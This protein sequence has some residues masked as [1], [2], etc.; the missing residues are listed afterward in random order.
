M[1]M[2]DIVSRNGEQDVSAGWCDIYESKANVC[3]RLPYWLISM[4][5]ME[6]YGCRNEMDPC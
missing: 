5:G 3:M 1:I 2:R 6:N 4:V